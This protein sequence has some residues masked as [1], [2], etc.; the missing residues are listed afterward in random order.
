MR[1]HLTITVAALAG[2]LATASGGHAQL[3]KKNKEHAKRKAAEGAAKT[4]EHVMKTSSPTVDS[5]LEK[6]G[7]GVDPA[8]S[9]AGAVAD[10]AGS[11]TE[12][13]VADAFSGRRRQPDRLAAEVAAGRAVV[14][15]LRFAAD[16]DELSPASVAL[17]RRLAK[18]I[19]ATTG[20]FLIEGHVAGSGDGARDQALSERRAAAVKA[21]LVLEGVPPA[22][23][24]AVGY[25]STR[26]VAGGATAGA[27]ARIE[28]ARVQ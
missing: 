3:L 8:V 2:A 23:L 4:P 11:K 16:S 24:M 28:L 5:T 13:G 25:G 20:I 21:R 10:T 17:V 26:P 7:R 19:N 12:Q 15:D 22:R 9:S 27:S 14:R 1:V 6:T 18:A